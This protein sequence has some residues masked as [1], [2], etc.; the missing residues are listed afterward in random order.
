MLRKLCLLL[1]SFWV[2]VTATFFL[3]HTLPGDPFSQE[4]AL[5]QEILHAMRVHYGLD[6]PLATQYL[7]YIKGI[8]T[9]DLGPSLRCQGRYVTDIIC[10]GFPV[11][12]TLGMGALTLALF[13]GVVLG[14]LSALYRGRMIDRIFLLIS[15][16]GLSIPAFLLATLLQYFFA[17]KLSLFPVARWGSLHH[18]ILPML[19]LAALPASFIA[20]LVRTSILDILEQDYI[21]TARA[22]GLSPLRILT[23]HVL[24]NA[25]L[26]ILAYLGPL[27]ASILTGGFAVERVFGIP[28]LGKWFV[29]SIKDRDYPVIMG[30]AIFYSAILMITVF[31]F[32]SLSRLCDPRTF[33]QEES[34]L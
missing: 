34:L 9:G 5:P 32:E 24:R 20:R 4:Q 14:A 18:M 33:S 26:P 29:L 25:L 1:L 2:I 28:G 30:T 22:K 8:A 13:S 7:L 16:L 12:F 3:M 19:A 23:H 31:I 11:S 6:K 21:Q 10:Q 15:V 17:M 27:T